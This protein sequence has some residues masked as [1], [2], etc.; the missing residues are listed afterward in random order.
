MPEVVGWKGSTGPML[1]STL[2][3]LL[4]AFGVSCNA[5]EERFEQD[6]LPKFST[7]LKEKNTNYV[8]GGDVNLLAKGSPET[9]AIKAGLKSY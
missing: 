5:Q 9:D 6:A 3:F 1:L 8:A 2:L 7:L 4:V